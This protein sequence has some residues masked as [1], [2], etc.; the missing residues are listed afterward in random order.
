MSQV[1]MNPV[2]RFGTWSALRRLQVLTLL[3]LHFAWSWWVIVWLST[4]IERPYG[5]APLAGQFSIIVI[6]VI[7]GSRMSR[8]G[9][10]IEQQARV[11]SFRQG[12][13]IQRQH[14]LRMTAAKKHLETCARISDLLVCATFIGSA[15]LV[16][17]RAM[18]DRLVLVFSIGVISVLEGANQLRS[19]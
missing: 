12:T 10:A 6:L 8:R 17:F 3:L 7:L 5:V 1:R 11:D 4:G 19:S 2:A 9:V 15:Y 16:Y 13:A 14:L 18:P